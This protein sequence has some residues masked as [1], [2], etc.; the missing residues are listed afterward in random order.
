MQMIGTSHRIAWSLPELSAMLGLSVGFLRKEARRGALRTRRM[1]RRVLVT[2]A[3]LRRFLGGADEGVA[4][5]SVSVNRRRPAPEG[6][7]HG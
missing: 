7:R 5:S 6:R 3:D 1:G 2:E 4:E